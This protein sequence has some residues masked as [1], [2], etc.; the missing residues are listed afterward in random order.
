MVLISCITTEIGLN[1]TCGLW[2]HKPWLQI[3]DFTDY[4]HSS[5]S[6]YEN[7]IKRYENIIHVNDVFLANSQGLPSHNS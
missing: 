7:G 6:F 5:A 1:K 2:G 4:E 3:N